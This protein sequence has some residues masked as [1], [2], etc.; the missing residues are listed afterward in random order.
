MAIFTRRGFL[1]GG[2]A[3]LGVGGLSASALGAW[4]FAIEPGFLL[5]VA[6][7]AFT[8]PRWPAGL[9]LKIAVVADIH[10]CEPW[11]PAERV[12][13][14]CMAANAL[15]PDVTFLLGDYY[16]GTTWASAPVAPS[17]W[18]EAV[19]LLRAPLG[20]YGVLGNHDIW[21]G[22][23]PQMRGDDGETVARTL[24]QASVRVLENDAVRIAKDGSPLWI[25]GLAD[26]MAM[27]V[28]PGVFRGR[29]DL[30]RT[31]GRI[32]DDAPVILLAHEPFIFP[33]VPERV[34]LTLCGHTHGGQVNLPGIGNPYL[35][36]RIKREH[37]YGHVVE[38]GRH[39]VVSAGLGV[40]IVP[41]RFNRPP[42]IVQITLGETLVASGR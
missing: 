14:I 27:R 10:A 35:N 26:Q 20:V 7:Y 30:D 31:L 28:S 16:G 36:R 2:V 42:E 39:M 41:A 40:S 32:D 6:S 18:G 1:R 8:P 15:E 24:K 29:D 3:T 23:L 9:R 34:S 25:A 21:H 19:S 17:A 4:T 37:S 11:M 22:P 5:D 33:R 38:D 13:R 12:R